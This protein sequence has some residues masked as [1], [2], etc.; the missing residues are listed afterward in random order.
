MLI[1]AGILLTLATVAWVLAPIVG[2]AAAPLTDAPDLIAQ[3]RE[4]HA[5]KDV[6]YETIRDLEF[7]F[8]AGKIGEGDFRELT[9]RYT[10]EAVQIVQRIDDL[11]ASLPRP[12]ERT[13]SGT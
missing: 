12:P 2:E 11:Q 7:D 5:L 13:R 9:D 3:M 1:L 8:H 4:L 6:A 10:R